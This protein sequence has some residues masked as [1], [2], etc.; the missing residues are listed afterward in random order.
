MGRRPATSPASNPRGLTTEVGTQFI[1][2]ADEQTAHRV[3]ARRGKHVVLAVD[4][5]R[6]HQDGYAFTVSAN[7]VW[8]VDHVPAGYLRRLHSQDLPDQEP[9]DPDPERWPYLGDPDDE[10]N[11]WWDLRPGGEREQEIAESHARELLDE[12]APNHPLYGLR[13]EV[14]ATFRPADDILIRLEDQ[15]WALVHL[16]YKRPERDGWPETDLLIGREQVQ[17]AIDDLAAR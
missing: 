13:F 15:R 7:G 17:V 2:S 8:L 1:L 14:V 10:E 5:G 3:G 11:P 12:L 9:T 16:T 4:A 6:V